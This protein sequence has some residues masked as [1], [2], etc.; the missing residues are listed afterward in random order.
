MFKTRVR[1]IMEY[2]W[3][4]WQGAPKVALSK[5]DTIQRKACKIMGKTR[6]VIPDL[7]LQSLAHR[8]KISGLCQVHHMVTSVAPPDVCK[9]LPSFN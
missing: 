6:D 9:L 3:P 4:I 1:S 8:R 7:N 5:L 2:C